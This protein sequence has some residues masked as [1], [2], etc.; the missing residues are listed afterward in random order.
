MTI[1]GLG[2]R[3]LRCVIPIAVFVAVGCA[4]FAA[5]PTFS[6]QRLITAATAT[7]PFDVRTGDIDLDGDLDVFTANYGGRVAWYENDG[8]DP[9]GP[10]AEHI[11][12]SPDGAVSAFAIRVDGDAD[13]DFFSAAFNLDEIAW[14]RND[15]NAQTWTKVPITFNC[16][17]CSDVWAADLDADGDNDAISISGFDGKV[18]WYENTGGSWVVR[19]IAVAIAEGVEAAD[20]DQDGDL[21]V[22]AGLS[23]YESD[24]GSPPTFQERSLPALPTQ[25][26]NR[27]AVLDVDRDG[28]PDIL[29]AGAQGDRIDWFENNG[30]LPPRWTPHVVSTTADAATSVYAADLDGDAD[31]DVLASSGGD[32][33][34]AWYENDGGSPPSWTEHAISTTA[35]GARSVFAADLEKDG[36]MDVVSASQWDARVVWHVNEANYLDTD[37]DGVRDE[38]DCAPGDGTAFAVPREVSGARFRSGTLEW[39]SAGAGSGS[40]ARYDVM[41]G[42]LSQLPPGPGSAETCLANEAAARTLTDG[43]IPDPRTGFY[44]LVRASN[45]CGVGSFG[46]GSSGVPRNTGACP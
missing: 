8:G 46:A 17:N 12:D 44:Y 3:R 20:L 13:I 21:D 4:I 19:P 42:L 5:P 33:T 28:D 2:L 32:D 40:G 16:R 35:F 9:P 41:R 26:A 18:D 24:G 7:L 36:D 10:W 39:N 22:V 31:V 37:H 1:V 23:W 15:G 25:L 27:T 38:L 34:I 11:I 30:A 6:T 43:A 45:P 29:T 14:H